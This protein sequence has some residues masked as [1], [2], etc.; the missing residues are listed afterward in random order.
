M[1]EG[2]EEMPARWIRAKRALIASYEEA[3]DD[4]P[5]FAI[6]D[7]LADLRHLCDRLGISYDVCDDRALDYY[8]DER[9]KASA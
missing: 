4:D 9:L 8:Q 1:P 3:T 7:L 6:G 2:I 5:E